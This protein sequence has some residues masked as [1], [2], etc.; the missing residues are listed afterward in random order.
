[1]GV[2]VRKGRQARAHHAEQVQAA[3]IKLADKKSGATKAFMSAYFAATGENPFSRSHRV[4]NMQDPDNL[5]QTEIIEREGRIHISS[6]VST[7]KSKGNASKVMQ[8]ICAIA[9]R[10]GAELELEAV[11][12]G[13]KRKVLNTKQL[14]DWYAKFGFVDHEYSTEDQP[15]MIRPPKSATKSAQ[16]FNVL[17]RKRIHREQNQRALETILENAR[18]GH[19]SEQNVSK[20]LEHTG[21]DPRKKKDADLLRRRQRIEVSPITTVTPASV[22]EFSLQISKKLGWW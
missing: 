12:F 5:V 15:Y 14:H 4:W 17:Q 8:E 9:D 19:V 11:P 6:I 16:A 21:L 22:D 20:V 18:D 2:S 7:A 10:T 1:M 3:P 13:D